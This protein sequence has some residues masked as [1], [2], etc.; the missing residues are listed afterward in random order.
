MDKREQNKQYH[1]LNGD[2]LKEQF[3]KQ[4]PG[5]TFIMRECLVDGAVDGIELQELFAT[6][7]KFISTNYE[8][9]KESDY[10]QRSVTEFEKMQAIPDS[11][12]I[13]LWFEEDLFCQVNLW[14][15]INLLNRTE[16]NHTLFLIRPK[17]GSEYSFADM[18]ESELTTAF[19]NRTKIE[20]SEAE[21]VGKLWELY[22]KEECETMLEIGKKLAQKFPFFLPAIQAHIDRL[23]KNGNPGRPAQSVLKIMDELK[24]E[25]FE[26]IFRE[27]RKRESIYGFGDL[28]V[29]RIVDQVMSKIS[30]F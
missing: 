24:T 11:S 27:F 17:A 5:E 10:Y 15:V 26:P 12:A 1:I 2:A 14:F 22:Q 23:P 4:I 28:Q 9:A 16:Q 30:T 20:Q 8:G 19:E 21:T 3:P 13:Y 18:N 7:A 6:R 25:E 29:K